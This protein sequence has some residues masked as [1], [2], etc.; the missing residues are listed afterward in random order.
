[1]W[2]ELVPADHPFYSL[3][4]TDASIIIYSRLYPNGIRVAGAGAGADQTASGLINDIFQ[5]A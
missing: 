4:G 1:M 2:L 5:C 3:A